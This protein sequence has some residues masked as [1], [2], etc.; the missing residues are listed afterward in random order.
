MPKLSP[1][2]SAIEILNQEED[3]APISNDFDK[4]I[5]NN[6]NSLN[7]LYN[8]NYSIILN[9][10]NSNLLN[11]IKKS[12]LPIYIKLGIIYRRFPEDISENSQSLCVVK[13]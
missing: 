7:S 4:I 5:S 1:V 8:L 2:Q 12:E 6:F 3:I 10:P 9:T 13:L 11:D